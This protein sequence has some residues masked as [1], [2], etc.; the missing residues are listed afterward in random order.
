MQV[1][2]LLEYIETL[3]RLDLAASWDRSGLQVAGS[4]DDLRRLGLTLDPTPGAIKAALDWGADFILTHHPLC[5]EPR[6]PAANDDYHQVL[7]LTLGSGSWLY[8]AHTSLDA[9][10]LGPV[11]WLADE[12]GLQGRQVIWPTK[13]E[14]TC[15]LHIQGL[16]DEG[17]L[18]RL[19][20]VISLEKTGD[21]AWDLVCWPSGL[22]AA[23]GLPAQKVIAQRLLS[24]SREYGFG[25][26][27]HLPRALPKAQ[28][29]RRL[30]QTLGIQAWIEI[31]QVPRSIS[32]IGYCPGSGSDF[33]PAAFAAGCDL[34]LTGDIKYHQA[35][36]LEPLGW[37]LDVGHFILEE[38]M[39]LYWARRIKEDL[40]AKDLQVRFFPGYDPMSRKGRSEA[41]G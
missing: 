17:L 11:A 2:E 5:I 32:V 19:P 38:K 13:T 1:K 37:T 27:G 6:L 16:K 18:Q 24:P 36:G 23:K 4:K 3:A 9:Q 21:H 22:S 33:A 35:Q 29:R 14:E 7:R 20:E 34:F 15:L 30:A 41:S 26:L 39:M 12:L 31:G 28:I 25:C 40:A 8:A 10:P